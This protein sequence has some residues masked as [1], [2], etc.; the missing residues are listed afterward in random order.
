MSA[1]R[2]GPETTDGANLDPAR[3]CTLSSEDLAAR[4]AWIRAEILPHARRMERLAAGVAWEL[5]AVPGLADALDRLI[6]LE[7]ACC[8]PIVFART[9]AQDPGR[10]RLEVR[11]V[12]PDALLRA[13]GAR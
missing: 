11:G 9:Q 1:H 5:D 3:A 7:R 2:R 6:A 4:I 13:L 10:L 8:D 12:D